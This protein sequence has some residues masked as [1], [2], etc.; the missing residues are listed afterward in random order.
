M[1]A[2]GLLL[3]TEALSLRLLEVLL[4]GGL[5]ARNALSEQ[6]LASALT[7]IREELLRSMLAV[8]ANKALAPNTFKWITSNP[9][10]PR[11][12]GPI[13]TPLYTGYIANRPDSKYCVSL[14]TN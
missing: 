13:G 11:L 9:S 8:H 10:S 2:H 1:A 5:L 3:D 14:V 12:G 7:L 6:Q 4:D